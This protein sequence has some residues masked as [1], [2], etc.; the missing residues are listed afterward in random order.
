M[1]V[2]QVHTGWTSS[3]QWAVP[4]T[5]SQQKD[6]LPEVALVNIC[7]GNRKTKKYQK[8]KTVDKN[9]SEAVATL[10]GFTGEGTE[11]ISSW[12]P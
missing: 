10:N 9:I 4:L 3:P 11:E 1:G 8:T 5:V 12:L 2:I 6:F 7:H